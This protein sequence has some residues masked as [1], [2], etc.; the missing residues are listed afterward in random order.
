MTTSAAQGGSVSQSQLAPIDNSEQTL[1]VAGSKKTN[2][3]VNP[4]AAYLHVFIGPVRCEALLDSG[5]EVSL[6]PAR[7]VDPQRITSTS[8][9]LKA[10]NGTVIA[11]LGQV[12][13]PLRIG[14]FETFVTGLVS[15]HVAEIMLGIEWLTERQV[16]WD[17]YRGRVKLGMSFYPLHSKSNGSKW[18]RRVV[19]QEAVTIPA[20]S[21]VDIPTKVV[22]RGRFDD[23]GDVQWGTETSSITPGVRVARTLISG[24]RLTDVLVRVLNVSME[25][26]SLGAGTTVADLQPMSVIG[27]VP[28][29]VFEESTHSTQVTTTESGGRPGF[30]ETLI[31]GVHG[32]LPETAVLTLEQIITKYSDVFSQSE[33]DLGLTQL[34]MHQIDTGSAKP[35]RQQLRRFPPAHVEAISNH[36]DSMLSQGI[37][38]PATSP[39]ASNLVLVRKKDGSFR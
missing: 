24:D 31:N 6:L 30:V 33:N 12:T 5:S 3:Q 29:E 19:L 9:T 20:R 1:R 37:I 32:S 17:F 34:V 38:E 15:E 18:C 8:Q 16:I 13:L 21:E 28:K 27:T 11:V 23:Q 14:R 2:Q 22:F 25:P 39:Y 4:R 26:I 10:A 36:V 35:I 7:Y